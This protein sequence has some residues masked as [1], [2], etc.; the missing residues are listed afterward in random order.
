MTDLY[1]ISM[2]VILGMKN[3]FLRDGNSF[4]DEFL[5]GQ[6]FNLTFALSSLALR[7]ALKDELKFLH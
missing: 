7:A 6:N 4:L 1:S 5:K 3:I 2:N